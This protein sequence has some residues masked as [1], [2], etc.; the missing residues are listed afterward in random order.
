[1]ASARHFGLGKGGL[2]VIGKKSSC[3]HDLFSYRRQCCGFVGWLPIWLALVYVHNQSS[4]TRVHC[5]GL[6]TIMELLLASNGY[7][8]LII[9]LYI[10]KF[11]FNDLNILSCKFT[12]WAKH[13]AMMTS[14]WQME[15]IPALLDLCAGNSP[16]TGEFSSQ[17]PVTRS[18]DIFFDLLSKQSWGWRFQTPLCSLWRHCNVY[19]D[20]WASWGPKSPM[21]RLLVRQLV[22][23]FI[24]KIKSPHYWNF[25]KGIHRCIQRRIHLTKDQ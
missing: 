14:S 22:Q 23:A 7:V 16:V 18:F 24:K 21:T 9:A 3:S 10:L 6:R 12:K 20:T 19:S 2:I 11:C 17:R 8:G 1:M 4:G 25:V 13:L 15:T 5:A